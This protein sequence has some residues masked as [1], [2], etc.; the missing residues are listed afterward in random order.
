[1]SPDVGCCV[2]DVG[3]TMTDLKQR[4]AA[5]LASSPGSSLRYG[6]GMLYT[7]NG[8]GIQVSGSA[9]SPIPR[10]TYRDSLARDTVLFVS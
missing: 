6:E 2:L 3:A 8:D 1:V 9:Q 4:L 10:T 5:V 7:K